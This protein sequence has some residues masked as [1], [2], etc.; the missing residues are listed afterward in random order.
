M[1]WLIG[2]MLMGLK[3]LVVGLLCLVG[4]VIAYFFL[5]WFLA[6]LILLVYR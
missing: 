6:L 4:L 3:Y 2:C 5:T 1:N